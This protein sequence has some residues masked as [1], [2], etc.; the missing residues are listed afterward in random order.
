KLRKQ[1][2]AQI[3]QLKKPGLKT[4]KPGASTGLNLDEL[5]K[6]MEQNLEKTIASARQQMEL[7]AKGEFPGQSPG[8]EVTGNEPVY[9]L[10][11]SP[12]GR[13]VA[14]GTASGVRVFSWEEIT[15]ATEVPTPQFSADSTRIT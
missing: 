15:S 7:I 13:W 10:G 6:S 3:A 9:S 1:L 12:D 8:S 2:E 14:C 11:I 4:K 5:I